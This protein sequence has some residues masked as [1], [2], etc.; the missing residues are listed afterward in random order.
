MNNMLLYERKV[1]CGIR[2]GD[3][4]FMGAFVIP[5]PIAWIKVEK[6]GISFGWKIFHYNTAHKLKFA[7]IEKIS[8]TKSFLFN[9]Y[10]IY[11]NNEELLN[12]IIIS[13]IDS[14]IWDEIVKRKS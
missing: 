3:T 7:Q 14:K 11:H 1:R 12:C 13:T 9:C 4:L 5:W 6:S 8:K 2:M 10:R